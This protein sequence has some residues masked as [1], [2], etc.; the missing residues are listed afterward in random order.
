MKKII[1][2]ALV[3]VMLCSMATMIASAAD[4]TPDNMTED[5]TISYSA[6]EYYEVTI[7]PDITL[8]GINEYVVSSTGVKV[9]NASLLEGNKLKVT[10][11]SANNFTVNMKGT[12]HKVAYSMRYGEN[13]T[14]VS[15]ATGPITLIDIHSGVTTANCPIAFKRTGSAA[16]SG[17]YTDTITFT[18]SVYRP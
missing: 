2:L 13:N 6:G 3:V 5:I 9:A 7:P 11:Q 10:A 14:E 8:G 4:L 16:V 17:D 12:T 18:V 15:S 1:A